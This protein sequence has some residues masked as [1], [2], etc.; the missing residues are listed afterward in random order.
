MRAFD[1]KS[2]HSATQVVMLTFLT[3]AKHD[4]E[5]LFGEGP[6]IFDDRL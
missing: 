5:F 6:V 4:R 3:R 1:L 2:D